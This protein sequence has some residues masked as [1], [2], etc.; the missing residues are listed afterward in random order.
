MDFEKAFGPFNPLL[1]TDVSTIITVRYPTTIPQTTP[2]ATN[3]QSQTPPPPPLPP[4]PPPPPPTSPPP[5]PSVKPDQPKS[6]TDVK[7]SAEHSTG[8]S[9]TIQ[10]PTPSTPPPPPPV[11]PDQSNPETDLKERDP[12]EQPETIQPTI[13]PSP[14]K[15]DQSES[16]VGSKRTKPFRQEEIIPDEEKIALVIADAKPKTNQ[17]TVDQQTVDSATPEKLFQRNYTCAIYR[18]PVIWEKTNGVYYYDSKGRKQFLSERQRSMWFNGDQL[19]G[20]IVGCDK[21]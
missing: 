8:Q 1:K 3:P 10:H 11:K 5:P 7:Q 18:L 6:D 15:P 21:K 12:T 13:L 2:Q 20:Y 9:E 19:T 16:I 14:V 4:P 17:K